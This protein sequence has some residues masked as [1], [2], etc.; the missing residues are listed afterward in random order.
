MP[1]EATHPPAGEPALALV[2]SRLAGAFTAVSAL[3]DAVDALPADQANRLQPSTS[4]AFGA[5]TEC[6]DVAAELAAGTR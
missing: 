4:A 6:E 3:T 2:L 1:Y 5:L